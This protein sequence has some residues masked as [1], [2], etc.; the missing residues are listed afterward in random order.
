MA[1][2]LVPYFEGWEGMQQKVAQREAKVRKGWGTLRRRAPL[3][4]V[5]SLVKFV[6]GVGWPGWAGNVV[7]VLWL[8]AGA[9]AVWGFCTGDGWGRVAVV[10][11][12]ANPDINLEWLAVLGGGILRPSGVLFGFGL[13]W[14]VA[15]IRATTLQKLVAGLVVATLAVVVSHVGLWTSVRVGLGVDLSIPGALSRIEKHWLGGGPV[16]WSLGGWVVGWLIVWLLLVAGLTRHSQPLVWVLR[17]IARKGAGYTLRVVWL[18][19]FF[20]SI[21]VLVYPPLGQWLWTLN[22]TTVEGLQDA[23]ALAGYPTVPGGAFVTLVVLAAIAGVVTMSTVAAWLHWLVIKAMHAVVRLANA[24]DVRNRNRTVEVREGEGEEETPRERLIR[25][26]WEAAL[27]AQ[28]QVV[29]QWQERVTA[30]EEAL[31]AQGAPEEKKAEPRPEQKDEQ[32]KDEAAKEEGQESQG[33][34]G[35]EG[36][37]AGSTTDKQAPAVA[38]APGDTV[39]DGEPGDTGDGAQ[40][41]EPA[42]TGDT[43]PGGGDQVE[44]EDEKVRAARVAREAREAQVNEEVE[45]ELSGIP[46]GAG[47]NDIMRELLEAESNLDRGEYDEVA[48]NDA[49]YVVGEE[50]KPDVLSEEQRHGDVEGWMKNVKVDDAPTIGAKNGAELW[51]ANEAAKRLLEQRDYILPG[52]PALEG[53][54]LEELEGRLGQYMTELC[55]LDIP[56]VWEY[57][58]K[59]RSDERYA[60]VFGYLDSSYCTTDKDKW[61]D[62]VAMK[63][64]MLQKAHEFRKDERLRK[65]D[66]EEA[67][68]TLR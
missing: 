21:G 35:G 47:I 20:G 51:Q 38:A 24:T 7:R 64:H 9:G 59:L 10:V 26:R 30:L 36:G 54:Y 43:R 67:A 66:L 41:T 12:V 15:W 11:V 13:V 4:W 29:E 61:G 27:E 28:R 58:E 46:Q 42:G 14:A 23:G 18:F 48:D 57:R 37:D 55:V 5:A 49:G 45:G 34:D 60:G 25:E 33:G 17:W 31:G 6:Q 44:D 19:F 40:A 16:K 50:E 52:G 56:R 2:S 1:F 68:R 32:Q 53:S 3:R 22:V 8:V 62:P 39:Q 65:Q 63:A